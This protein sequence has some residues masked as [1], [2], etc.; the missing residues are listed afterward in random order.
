MNN[1]RWN[2]LSSAILNIGFVN[3]ISVTVSVNPSL[4]TIY[5]YIYICEP[6][7]GDSGFDSKSGD[8]YSNLE[9]QLESAPTSNATC[10]FPN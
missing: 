3:H 8:S 9:C 6:Y 7:S 4:L 10:N 1:G 2:S 5:I